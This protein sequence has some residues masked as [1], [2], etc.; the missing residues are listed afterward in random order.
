MQSWSSIKLWNVSLAM[1]DPPSEPLFG[2]IG[3]CTLDRFS[4]KGAKITGNHFTNGAALLGRTKSSGAVIRGN[5][6]TD[7]AT[8]TLEVM[9][10]QGFMEGPVEIH[11]VL[12]EENTLVRS[13][14]NSTSPVSAGPNTTG[15]TFSD[16]HIVP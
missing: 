1:P 7:T 6:W 3:V 16:N 8:H 13:T 11:S 15:V 2:A 9:A 10:L 4:G 14:D 5:T 12:I